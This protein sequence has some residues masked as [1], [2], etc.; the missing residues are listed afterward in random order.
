MRQIRLLERL[1]LVVGHDEVRLPVVCL[2][3]LVDIADVGVVQG[4]CRLGFL[5]EPLLRGLVAGQIRGG[6]LMATWR[7]RRGSCPDQTANIVRMSAFAP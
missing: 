2:V 5:E 3:D 1:P 7:F 6:S 4:G